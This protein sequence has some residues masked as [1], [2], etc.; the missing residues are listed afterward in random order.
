MPEP[1]FVIVGNHDVPYWDAVARVLHPWRAFET[2][3]GFPAP[4]PPRER[5]AG[6]HVYSAKQESV[7]PIVETFEDGMYINRLVA[8]ED[9]PEVKFQN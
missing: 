5:P 3:T 1:R 2:A 9:N 4:P 8:E 7:P 6:V